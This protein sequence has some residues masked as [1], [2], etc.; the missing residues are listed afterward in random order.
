M[1]KYGEIRKG[2]RNISLLPTQEMGARKPIGGA[3][4]GFCGLPELVNS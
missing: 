2:G 3:Y 1:I 4:V